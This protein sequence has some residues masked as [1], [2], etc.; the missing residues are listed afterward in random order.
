MVGGDSSRGRGMGSSLAFPTTSVGTSS[1]ATKGL[2]ESGHEDR[3][4]EV[5]PDRSLGRGE[6][7]A[8]PKDFAVVLLTLK[9]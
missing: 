5:R 3:V 6:R 4:N 2:F 1:M 9:R 8:R 7:K